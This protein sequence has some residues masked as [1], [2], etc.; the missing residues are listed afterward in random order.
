MICTPARLH[1]QHLSL[2]MHATRLVCC[3]WQ[4]ALAQ[5]QA[6]RAQDK[7]LAEQAL[8]RQNAAVNAVHQEVD[9]L[10]QEVL[11]QEDKVCSR[12]ACH[13]GMVWTRYEPGLLTVIRYLNLDQISEWDLSACVARAV[14]QCVGPMIQQVLRCWWR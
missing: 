1:N 4:D 10:L 2:R 12:Q 14:D 8:A 11:K 7:A 9:I 3:G 6:E 5:A 13:V